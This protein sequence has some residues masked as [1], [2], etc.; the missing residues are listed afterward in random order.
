MRV[1]L[2]ITIVIVL[3]S[4]SGTRA[5]TLFLFDDP[6]SG[7]SAEA[8][9][10]L[11]N[12]TT[13]GIRLK[14]T[15]TAPL[16]GDFLD[17]ASDQILTGIS[18]DMGA[19]GFNGDPEITG[20]SVLIG[21][22]SASVDFDQIA[23]QLG[24][25]DDVSG[26]YGFGN[27]DGTGALTNFVSANSA[28]ATPFGGLNLDDGPNIDG[29]Q[30]GL[31][32]DPMVAPNGGL[33]VIQDEIDITVTLSLPLASEVE[34][35]GDLGLVRVEFGSDAAFITVPEPGTLMLLSVAALP[36]LLRRRRT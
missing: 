21:A 6:A 33:G 4:C 15:S 31:V 30:S 34:I 27:M 25:G 9:F 8:E 28:Q 22:A 32:A 12:A 10:T 3:A 16:P 36:L 11:I 24:P 18:W 26:E 29:P 5:G 17:P 13:I 20:G 23:L 1:P 19:V 35:F 14:N 2:T 7:L